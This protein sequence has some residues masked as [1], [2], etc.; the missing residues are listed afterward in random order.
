MSGYKRDL[1]LQETGQGKTPCHRSSSRTKCIGGGAMNQ[2]STQRRV[3]G[4]EQCVIL[5]IP[6]DRRGNIQ[7]FSFTQWHNGIRFPGAS[8]SHTDVFEEYK[9]P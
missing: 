6:T 1:K 8:H 7:F 5:V 4:T 9:I 2:H 3:H